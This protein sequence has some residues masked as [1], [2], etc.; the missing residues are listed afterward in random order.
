MEEGAVALHDVEEVVAL[1]DLEVHGEELTAEVEEVGLNAAHDEVVDPEAVEF[2]VGDAHGQVHGPLEVVLEQ[3]DLAIP[4]DEELTFG[5][6]RL[7]VGVEGVR[8]VHWVVVR[9]KIR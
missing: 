8:E 4:G 5:L 7:G 1:L 9:C 6:L 3:G 2:G